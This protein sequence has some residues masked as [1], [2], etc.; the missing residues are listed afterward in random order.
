[1]Q[2]YTTDSTV[3]LIDPNNIGNGDYHDE[4]VKEWKH[5]IFKPAE[6]DNYHDIL[7]HMRTSFYRDEPLNHLAGYSEEKARDMDAMIMEY[8]DDGLSHIVLEKGTNQVC[9]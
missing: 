8:F 4:G 6:P 2:N 1:M 9:T 3:E 7:N 5:F